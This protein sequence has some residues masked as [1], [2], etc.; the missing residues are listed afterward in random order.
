MPPSY[1]AAL[2]SPPFFMRCYNAAMKK[3]FQF[4]M[5]RMFVLTTIFCIELG[6]FSALVNGSRA[7]DPETAW[8]GLVVIGALCG[9][10]AGIF[11][12][13]AIGFLCGIAAGVIVQALA[14]IDE[15]SRS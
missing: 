10:V 5:R 8:Y 14:V 7:R 6:L 9:L 11:C 1:P 13:P 4:S 12:K 3:P 2:A 15:L